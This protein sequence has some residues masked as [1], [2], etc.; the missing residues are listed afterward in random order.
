MKEQIA[1]SEYAELY[2]VLYQDKDYLGECDYLEKLFRKHT[3]KPAKRLLDVAA[4][5]GNH[6][7]IFAAKGYDVTA[8][9]YSEEMAKEA[10]KKASARG[11]NLCVQGGISMDS[12]P[13][14]KARFDVVMALFSAINYLT[15]PGS[16]EGFL[17]SSKRCLTPEGVLIFDFWNGLT[18]QTGYSPLR[19][20]EGTNSQ[21]RV[22]RISETRLNPMK[23]EAEVSFRCLVFKGESKM[24][25][26]RE[27]HHLRYF[28]PR[29][30]EETLER[31]GYEL[32]AFQPFKDTSRSAN[33]NDWNLTIVARPRR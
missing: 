4:G 25:E 21:M 14:P 10:L 30:M 3:S 6:A 29:E 8:Y 31:C 23:H 9:D 12:M 13:E 1:F 16:L 24:K 18:C 22:I 15:K 7:L 17:E 11:L 2:D 27:T 33:E 20:K 5:T 26:V 28:Y 19:V 32:L